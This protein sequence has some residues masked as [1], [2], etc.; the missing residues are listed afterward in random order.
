[1]QINIIVFGQL[2]DLLGE[3]IVLN[4]IADTDHLTMV[5]NERYPELVDSKYMMAVDKKLV[6]ENTFLTDNSTV[7]L[8]PAFSGG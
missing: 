3:K 8:L 4:N 6:N 7:A 2:V 1:M 5:L